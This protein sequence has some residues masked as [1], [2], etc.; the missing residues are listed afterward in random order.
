MS[1]LRPLIAALA[2]G[3]SNAEAAEA[4]RFDG[5]VLDCRD[6]DRSSDAVLSRFA[7]EDTTALLK[8]EAEDFD[9][10]ENRAARERYRRSVER[11]NARSVRFAERADRLVRRGRIGAEEYR[12]RQRLYRAA[13]ANYRLAID[14]YEASWW[15]DPIED[16][17]EGADGVNDAIIVKG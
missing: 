13:Y 5:P 7:S 4:C 6:G 15:F 11:N 14:R 2:L 1:T 9:R 17:D 8:A 16:A 10:F 3:A 12:R